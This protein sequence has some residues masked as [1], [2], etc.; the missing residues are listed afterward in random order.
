MYTIKLNKRMLSLLLGLGMIMSVFCQTGYP[1][2]VVWNKD[3]VLLITKFQLVTINRLINKGECSEAQLVLKNKE[4]IISDSI[5]DIQ[6]YQ[7][8]LKDSIIR[9]Q[10]KDIAIRIKFADS[11]RAQLNE[12]KH[13]NIKNI[14][15]SSGVGVSL[16]M[17]LTILLIR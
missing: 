12:E 8:Y 14:F 13:K 17:L 3:T 9:V 1:K 11:V 5:I 10:N 6:K 4:G 7:I 15:V 2:K 16:G